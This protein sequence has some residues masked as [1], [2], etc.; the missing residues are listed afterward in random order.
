MKPRSLTSRPR[1]M[2][3][4]ITSLLLFVTATALLLATTLSAST[5]AEYGVVSF[6]NSFP[7]RPQCC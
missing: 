6:R 4:S 3:F 1:T 2:R 7:C 5:V